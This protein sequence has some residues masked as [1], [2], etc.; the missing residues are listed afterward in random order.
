MTWAIQAH[1]HTPYVWAEP[2]I[3]MAYRGFPPLMPDGTNY[4]TALDAGELT[5]EVPSCKITQGTRFGDVL[6]TTGGLKLVSDRLARALA[7]LGATGYHLFEV[8]LHGKDG[9]IPGFHG[10]AATGSEDDDIWSWGRTRQHHLTIVS[11]R[12]LNGLI[13]ADVT[14]FAREPMVDLE[15]RLAEF[16]RKY[17]QHSGRRSPG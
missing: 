3:P 11:D 4:L 7:D 14:E 16:R 8:D 9:P 2:R 10:F 17:P 13:A 12:V 15:A 5:G 1:S 6:W